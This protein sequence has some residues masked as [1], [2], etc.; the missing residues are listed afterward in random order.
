M[1]KIIMRYPV[2]F[3]TASYVTLYL[4]CFGVDWWLLTYRNVDHK[5]QPADAVF[6]A[7]LHSAIVF[8]LL[9]AGAGIFALIYVSISTAI[10]RHRQRDSHANVS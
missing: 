9:A 5:F 3:V 7:L 10:R 6:W 4:L 2:S 8:A 1:M